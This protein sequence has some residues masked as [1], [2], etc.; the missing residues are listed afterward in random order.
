MVAEEVMRSDPE[1]LAVS[2][3]ARHKLLRVNGVRYANLVWICSKIAS[4]V[5]ASRS[6][7]EW[8]GRPVEILIVLIEGVA[9]QRKHPSV[10]KGA[11]VPTSL[12]WV[13]GPLTTCV[14]GVPHD[15]V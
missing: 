1:A 2:R 13:V 6:E 7:V 10:A 14:L 15:Y 3:D 8:C 5:A 4:N 9:R 11:N 12:D